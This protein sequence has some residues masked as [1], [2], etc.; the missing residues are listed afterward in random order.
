MATVATDDHHTLQ[1]FRASVGAQWTFLEDPGRIVQKDLDIH[2]YTDPENDPMIPYTLVLRPGLVIH[3]IYNG[4]WFRGRPSFV[5]LWHDL[6]AVTAVIRPDRG[7]ST[8]GRQEAW[9]TGDWSPFHGSNRRAAAR[10]SAA[11]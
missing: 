6:R 4:H 11:R 1:E 9:D 3:A 2:E 5:D 10:S 7:L 8:P